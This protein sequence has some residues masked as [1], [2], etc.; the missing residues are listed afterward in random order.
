M[1]CE[2]GVV[3]FEILNENL[4][5]IGMVCVGVLVG[6]LIWVLMDVLFYSIEN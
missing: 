3:M 1:L 5:W 6:F 2:K 4:M